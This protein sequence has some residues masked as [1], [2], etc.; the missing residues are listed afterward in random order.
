M[1][2]T[3]NFDPRRRLRGAA[4]AVQTV[5]YFSKR[6][7]FNSKKHSPQREHQQLETKKVVFSDEV[8]NLSCETTTAYD[9][10]CGSDSKLNVTDNFWE[11]AERLS[12]G[13][14]PCRHV[15]SPDIN[16]ATKDG[17]VFMC[18]SELVLNSLSEE[19][20]LSEQNGLF[21]SNAKHK[22]I[23]K[24]R[25]GPSLW[26]NRLLE[27]CGDYNISEGGK[28]IKRKRPHGT[29]VDSIAGIPINRPHL[30]EITEK[31]PVNL[32]QFIARDIILK[33]S[34]LNM[35]KNKVVG[36]KGLTDFA[37]FHI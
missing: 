23:L 1:E 30:P 28:Q 20:I 29:K 36:E 32:G 19:S 15:S 4:I 21:W 25:H 31:D 26:G 7:H 27:R 2:I 35:D 12:C 13:T 18:N 33:P 6:T 9:L 11:N 17:R 37:T 24:T 5:N 3:R 10:H 34:L 14:L 8:L 22:P 16:S